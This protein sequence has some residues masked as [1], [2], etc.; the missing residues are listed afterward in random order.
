MDNKVSLHENWQHVLNEY[1]DNG[2]IQEAGLSGVV[3]K[4]KNIGPIKRIRQHNEFDRQDRQ[5]GTGNNTGVGKRLLS[6]ALDVARGAAKLANGE[7]PF[8]IDP[9]EGSYFS[10]PKD[11]RVESENMRQQITSTIQKVVT[12]IYALAALQNIK[13]NS[14]FNYTRIQAFQNTIDPQNGNATYKKNITYKMQTTLG[15]VLYDETKLKATAYQPLQAKLARALNNNA[16]KG[17]QF[18]NFDWLRKIAAKELYEQNDNLVN[19]NQVASFLKNIKTQFDSIDKLINEHIME[20]YRGQGMF[21]NIK[22]DSYVQGLLERKK[23]VGL[24]LLE[25]YRANMNKEIS[26][27][28][29]GRQ[30]MDKTT[31]V[32]PYLF[33]T[34]VLNQIMDDYYKI[35]QNGILESIKYSLIP[36][37]KQ[38]T[39]STTP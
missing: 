33:K 17:Q 5:Q 19:K 10:R 37:P 29:I 23:Q 1:Y 30:A 36:L 38:P 14:S 13:G 31:N 35:A 11:H 18:K 7:N 32:I 2:L 8:E 27:K 28:I 21:N 6:T 16:P 20:N 24:K 12:S 22:A 9:T 34:D 15:N 26:L 4:I 39:T 25:Q 3:D